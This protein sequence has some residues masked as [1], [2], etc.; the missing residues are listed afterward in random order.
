MNRGVSLIQ[1]LVAL[2]ALTLLVLAF[3]QLLDNFN[4]GDARL[5]RALFAEQTLVLVGKRI[6]E[7]DYQGIL[8]DYCAQSGQLRVGKC[9]NADKTL[10]TSAETAPDS[11]KVRY[12]EVRLNEKSA[13]DP[14]GT[15]CV[16]VTKCD[17]KSNSQ[18]L[19]LLLTAFF[20][21]P[22]PGFPA[23]SQSIKLRK[24]KW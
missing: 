13:P 6:L 18:I 21:N 5:D 9:L 1:V 3:F 7:S 4:K 10:N 2:V 23:L 16:E 15:F 12:L 19:E 24:A 22:E 14:D 8:E 17:L 11:N 20:S